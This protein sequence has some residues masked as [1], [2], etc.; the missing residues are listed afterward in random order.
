[1]RVKKGLAILGLFMLL[2]LPAMIYLYFIALR[3]RLEANKIGRQLDTKQ[4]M[5]S[6]GVCSHPLKYVGTQSGDRQLTVGQ[7]INLRIDLWN[8]GKVECSARVAVNAATFDVR[9]Q[10]TQDLKLPPGNSTFLW[11][12]APTRVG[13][14]QIV[15]QSGLDTI[16]IGL[17]VK[18]LGFLTEFQA[19]LF[20]W[21]VGLLGPILTVPWWVELLAKYKEKKRS[22]KDKIR[23]ILPGGRL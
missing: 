7:A 22:E 10:S 12:I 23:I 20:S 11:N 14:H 21:V 1:M 15:V 18:E 8:E 9:P 5:E 19:K 3:G 17:V 4:S 2:S 16:G 13:N 6:G